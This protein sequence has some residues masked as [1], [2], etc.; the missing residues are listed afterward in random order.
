MESS[1]PLG[2]IPSGTTNDFAVSLGIPLDFLEAARFILDGQPRLIDVGVFGRRFFSYVAAFGKYT[3]VSYSTAQSAKTI[4]GRAAYFFEGI[5]QLNRFSSIDCN[6]DIDGEGVAG[7]FVLGIIT[8]GTSV[9]GFRVQS[10]RVA[11]ID[12]GLFEA[13]FVRSPE[14]LADRS[15][16]I[17]AL[18]DSSVSTDIV[19]QRTANRITFSSAQPCRWTIDGEFGGEHTN[20]TVENLHR[21]LHIII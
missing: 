19:V 3:D 20:I 7:S 17:A 5:K 13:I 15:E 6:I 2:Y 16:I 8:N 1:P 4:F 9:A 11:S 18:T 21:V 10:G 12:D 14:T